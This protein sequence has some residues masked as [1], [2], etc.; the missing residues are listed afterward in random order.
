MGQDNSKQKRQRV[1]Y[2]GKQ[3]ATTPFEI[4]GNSLYNLVGNKDEALFKELGGTEGICKLLKSNQT[5]GLDG[6]D[7]KERYSQFGQNKYPDPI[8]K[9]FFQ[10]LVDSL[11]DS[12]LMILIASAF[13]SLFLALVMPKSQTCGEEQEMNTDWI[14]GLAIFV[15]VIVV[16]VGSSI[17][18]YNK[19]KKFMELSQDEKNVNIKVVRKGENT[20]ISIRDLAVGDLVNLDVGDIIPA[21]G[22]YASGFDLRVDESDMTG[23]PVAVKKSEKDYWMMSG[24]KVTDGNGQMIVTAVGLNS[25]WGKTKE[26]LNQDKPRP[27]PLQEKLDELAEQIGKLGM[28]CAIV[29]F[30]ILCIYWVIDAINYKPIL[31]CDNDPCKQWTEESKATHNCELIGF[32]WMH[33]ASVVE[34]LITAITIVVVAV[35]EGLPL[36][37]TISLAYSMQ[38]M[39]ADNNLVRHLKACEIMSNCSNIC[40]DKTGT[41]TENRMTVV[42][43]WF[44]GEV[45]ER[46][47]SLDLN[48]TKLGEEVYNNIS[49]NKSISSAVYM[50]DGILKTIG[51]K[52]ECALL[53]YCLKQNIDYEARYTKLS[54]IIYQQFAFSSARK[55]MSTIIYNEDKSL[56]MFLKGAPE[57]ILSKCSKYMKKDGTTVIL[58]ED[59]RKTLLDF[60]L[61]CANQGMRT[62]SLAVRDLSPKNPSNLN[63]KYEESP[64]E[65]CTLLCVFGI[66]DP[67]RPEVIDAVAS[68]HRAGITVRM[69]TGD[70]IATGRSIAKQCKIIESDSDFCIEGPQF[71]KLTDEEVDNILP[72]LRVIARCSPQDKKRLVNRLILHGE[73]VAVTGDGTND[74]PALKEA[75]VG[76]AMGI[77]G[78]DVAKQASDIVI[79]DDN[80]NSIVKAVMWGRC[81]YDN[82]RKFL[83]FQLT[84]NV[85]ALALC[86]IGAITKMGSPLKALQMLWVNMIM[87]T[88][89][90][91]ALG[92]E[93]PTPSLLNRK[94]FGRK[95]SLISINMLRNIVTQAIYQLFVLLFLLYCGRELTFLNAPCAYIDHG[96]FG[97]YKCADN[98]LHSINDIEKD[99]T[100]I[101]TMIFNAFVFCQIFNEI[102]SRK[103]NG[104][105]DVFENIFSNYMFV[106]IVSMT[107][108]VQTLIVVFAGPIFSVTPFPG[109]GIIQ[110]ITCLVLSS[111]SLVIGQLAIRYLTETQI[112]QI[113]EN[114]F[115]KAKSD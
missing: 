79:L 29:V 59:D 18:D 38:Q 83:Q 15:A 69:V 75:D 77:R 85:V 89:A 65:D 3:D 61:S 30:T 72:T 8:M 60:Q 115:G 20:L 1:E 105:I 23:E 53:G 9:T 24:T 82:I 109:I 66:E 103:V 106:G 70:N 98:K 47:K 102:N 7:L 28:G 99:T 43:G 95:A 31:V 57:V 4:S 107:A 90:A 32:N 33:L 40:T 110:W 100:T 68:C 64:E 19:Q 44:G 16:S 86:I 114:F 34:Y 17:S 46:D 113:K 45:M 55:R 22:V 101:Q 56:H 111:L 71:A 76:L 91:L 54:S 14:E 27:T 87:D 26:S 112:L 10:M 92:T 94:P 11:N 37:V 88:L 6:N 67:L 49:C 51:N 108:I 63:E 41:L 42:R 50:E 73:V 12:T 2:S 13:V 96:D 80:F 104:E 97:Q 74:V 25:L 52:T 48:N 93:K 35:P 5:K 39:M 58:T 21:D 36:A 62:L 84:V 81:V 78:T